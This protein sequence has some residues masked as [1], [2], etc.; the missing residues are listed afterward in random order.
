MS[1]RT[2]KRIT[3]TKWLLRDAL[4]V[5]MEEKG[6]EGI[7]VRDLTEKA[8]IN[9]GTFYLHYR[10]K[11]DLLEQSEDE[12]LLAVEE[13]TSEINPND[14]LAYT[15]QSEPFPIILRLF[16]FFQ[17]NASFMKV[18]LGPKG[19]ASFQVKLK[20]MIKKRFIQNIVHMHL[21]EDM[22]VPLDFFLSYVSSAH[23]GIVQHWLEN[24]MEQSPREMTLIAAR[25]TLLGPG[26]VAGLN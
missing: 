18:L 1:E 11:F 15:S 9:R 6:F 12:I 17:E 14:A 25:L 24:G 23:L 13:I 22:A 2:D 16:E 21:K 20:E 8:A 3:R 19:D 10:D 5:L 7:T 26:H 4:T